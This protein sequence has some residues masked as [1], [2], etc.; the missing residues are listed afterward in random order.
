MTTNQLVKGIKESGEDFEFYPTTAE[1][2]AKVASRIGRDTKSILDIGCGN[3]NFFEKL[4]LYN[5]TDFRKY[6]IEKSDFLAEQLPDD[7]VLLGSDFHENTLID[8]KVSVIFCNPPYSEYEEWTEKIIMQGNAKR[9][10]L[11]IPER[12]KNSERIKYALERRKF[13]AEIIGTYDFTNAERKAR[14]T[15][16]VLLITAKYHSTYGGY[17]KE[18]DPFN[19][20]FEETFKINADKQKKTTFNSDRK[21]EIEDKLIV[22]GDTAQM[23]VEFYNRDMQEL[24]NNYRALEKL[25]P[26]IF[27][28]LKV[29]IPKLK[30]SLKERLKGLKSIYWDLLFKKYDRITSRL[31]SWCRSKVIGRLHDNVSIDF[32]MKNIIMLTT[33]IIRHSNKLFDEQITEFF[34]T[35]CNSETIQQYK[36]NIRFNND[37]WCYIKETLDKNS[38]GR[39]SRDEFAKK[40]RYFKGI[41]LDYRIVVKAWSN[42][43]FGWSRPHLTQSCLNFLDD[44]I[45]IAK[46]LGFNVVNQLP[47]EYKEINPDDWR[48]FDLTTDKGEVFANVKLYK[49]GNRHVKFNKEFMK[50]LNIEMARINRWLRDKQQAMEEFDLTGE[51][52][53]RLWKSNIQITAGANNLLGLP[54]MTE[55]V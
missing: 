14:A 50:K 40:R 31:T 3:G 47:G 32:T 26:A 15:V 18:S 12:W 30:E 13:E 42:F 21:K 20:F 43:D 41:K 24:Y 27:E 37:D 54:D 16:D 55:E 48:N 22:A 44:V 36:S 19:V 33:W 11:V 52:V 9:I 1:I 39:L 10:F 8:K 4:K 5:D 23:L 38:E 34:F 25:D 46:N 7:V 53:N 2:V 28:E 49:N 6:G 51:E 29:D 17:E 45:V 35:L